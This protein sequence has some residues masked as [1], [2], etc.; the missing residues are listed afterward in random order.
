VLGA[1]RNLVLPRRAE[2]IADTD[3]ITE[4][5][6]GAESG[7]GASIDARCDRRT[8]ATLDI[9]GRLPSPGRQRSTGTSATC[10]STP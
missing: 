10:V 3:V 1:Q 9:P 5:E 7:V 6:G 4:V 8:D 2:R